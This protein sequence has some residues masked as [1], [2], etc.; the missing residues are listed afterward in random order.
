MMA[1]PREPTAD[2]STGFIFAL[3]AA[4]SAALLLFLP[5]VLLG[6]SIYIL[7]AL[8][9]GEVLAW[10]SSVAMTYTFVGIPALVSLVLLAIPYRLFG[11]AARR[12]GA[13]SA[14]VWVGGLLAVWH[15]AL[16]VWW[17]WSSTE[18]L[19]HAPVADV[20]FYPII[21]GIGAVVAAFWVDKR[22]AVAALALVAILALLITG[23]VRAR[24]PIPE[25]AQQLKVTVTGT[26]VTLEPDSVHAGDVY[27]VLETPRSTVTFTD[28]ELAPT[29]LPTR[30]DFRLAGC[31]D[32]QRAEDRGLQGYCGN[33]FRV[34]LDAGT[35]VF[36]STDA[37]GSG[38]A[39][40]RLEVLP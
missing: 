30:G 22:V 14:V 39:Q 36:F 13:R 38:Q 15:A 27:L 33:V 12:I 16:A 21:F 10:Q 25:G 34:T 26:D 23:T 11:A 37:E 32:A 35:Y 24:T 18:A 1:Q 5:I 6:Y 3:G 40:A 20:P 2:S 7:T 31:S 19:T 28:E 4:A 9:R 8:I 29:D 17:A